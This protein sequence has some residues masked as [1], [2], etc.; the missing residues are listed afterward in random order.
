MSGKQ[1]TGEELKNIIMHPNANVSGEAYIFERQGYDFT[2]S[3][4]TAKLIRLDDGKVTELN[5]ITGEPG[6][7]AC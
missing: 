7:W 6:T 1:Y 5:S 3:L 4:C 2:R